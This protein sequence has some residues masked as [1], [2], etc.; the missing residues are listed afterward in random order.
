MEPTKKD[1]PKTKKKLQPNG[2]RGV[3]TV[4]SNPIP[5]MWVTYNLENNNTKEVLPLL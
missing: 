1:I 5:T 4:K 2:R 3:S